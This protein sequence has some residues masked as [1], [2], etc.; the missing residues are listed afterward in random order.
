[1]LEGCRVLTGRSSAL[2]M[3]T[4]NSILCSSLG[5]AR[6]SGRLHRHCCV[7]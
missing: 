3:P 4:A 6:L 2:P 5:R 7:P 1:M